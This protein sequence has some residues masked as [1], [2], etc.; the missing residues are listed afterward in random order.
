[1]KSK[2]L[3]NIVLPPTEIHRDLNGSISFWRQ[4]KGST[5]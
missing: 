3:Q 5:S 1:M 2:D 4:A